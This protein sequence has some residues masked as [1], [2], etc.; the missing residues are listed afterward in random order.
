M[1][2]YC[3]T[4]EIYF[5]SHKMIFFLV[6][7]VFRVWTCTSKLLNNLQY[8]AQQKNQKLSITECEYQLVMCTAG[9]LKSAPLKAGNRKA[10]YVDWGTWNL[11]SG[12]RE[13]YT[14][15]STKFAPWAAW[16]D[17]LFSPLQLRRR[18]YPKT[19]MSNVFSRWMDASGTKSNYK[20]HGSRGHSDIKYTNIPVLKS[21]QISLLIRDIE[22][23]KQSRLVPKWVLLYM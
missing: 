3:E 23:K 7:R 20:G 16:D 13:M 9:S 12:E 10:W 18:R 14:I 8:I 17:E 21:S 6:D 2:V 1:A 15:L 11:H 19:T 5:R 4:A 22:D